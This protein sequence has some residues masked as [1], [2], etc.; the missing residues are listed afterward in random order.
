MAP[1]AASRAR[2]AFPS[3]GGR[4][5]LMER[6][7]LLGHLSPAERPAIAQLHACGTK[8]V[9]LRRPPAPPALHLCDVVKTDVQT[10]PENA[11]G[12]GP[13]TTETTPTIR[14]PSLR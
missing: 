11:I 10:E 1:S 12:V 8:R 14:F 2:T 7:T 13:S 5:T 9:R 4:A 3:A 6:S